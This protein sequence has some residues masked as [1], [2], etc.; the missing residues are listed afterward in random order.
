MDEETSRPLISC[1]KLAWSCGVSF[2]LW[3]LVRSLL[4]F[5]IAAA[6]PSCIQVLLCGAVPWLEG[7]GGVRKYA[8]KD[9]QLSSMRY[10][11][12]YRLRRA[13]V[14]CPASN[15][16]AKLSSIVPVALRPNS[17][18][19]AARSMSI[20]ACMALSSV[21]LSREKKSTSCIEVRVPSKGDSLV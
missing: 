18:S 12:W 7:E 1:S 20:V 21:C 11:A 14:S 4:P 16:A 6:I 2:K 19:A 13:A 15:V 3:I 8:T 5:C 17:T 10:L 9:P